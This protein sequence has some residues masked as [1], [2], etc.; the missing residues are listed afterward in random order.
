MPGNR[1]YSEPGA[2]TK[3]GLTGA[4]RAFA[5][6]AKVF[7]SQEHAANANAES[8]S[9]FGK[10]M[11][12]VQ[13]KTGDVLNTTG[14]ALMSGGKFA[15]DNRATIGFAICVASPLSAACTIAAVA[16][17][18]ADAIQ[19]G[20]NARKDGKSFLQGAAREGLI[21]GGATL[22]GYGL[23]RGLRGMYAAQYGDDFIRV[24]GL[25]GAPPSLTFHA[26]N[27]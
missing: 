2:K 17:I 12:T 10:I 26:L 3:K 11:D 22:V 8:K 7:N 13:N 15:W 16:V 19:G 4:Q 1:S 27:L 9:R 6:R 24:G 20:I 23:G 25:A 18:G 5:S 21:S 14:D